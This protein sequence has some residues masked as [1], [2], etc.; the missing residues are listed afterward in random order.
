MQSI[1]L[2]LITGWISTLVSIVIMTGFLKII[3]NRY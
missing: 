3:N 1:E 2:T